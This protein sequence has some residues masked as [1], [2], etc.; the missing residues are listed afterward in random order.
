MEYGVTDYGR[1]ISDTIRM[2]AYVGALERTIKPGNVVLDIGTGTGMMAL[3]ACRLGAARVIALEPDDVIEVARQTAQANGYDDRIEFIQVR[4]TEL[5]LSK[6]AD[7]IV[8]DLR[9]VLPLYSGHIGAI[10]DARD[11]LLAEGGS[12]IPRRDTL[13]VAAVEAP[14][15]YRRNV[16]CWSRHDLGFDLTSVRQLAANTWSRE[17]V[18]QSAMLTDRLQVAVLDYATINSPDLDASCE[19]SVRRKGTA[20]GLCV[21]FDT[22]LTEGEG[23]SNAPDRPEAIYGNAFLPFEQPVALQEGDSV[24]VHLRAVLAGGDYVWGWSTG[25]ERRGA[26]AVRYRQSSVLGVPLTAAQLERSGPGFVPTLSRQGES[27]K[28]ALELMGGESTL[29]LGE[30]AARVQQDFPEEFSNESDGLAFVVRLA[31]KYS[32]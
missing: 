13:W 7:V 10:I 5:Q 8:S 6:R 32:R 18:E 21:W 16:D 15:A 24:H 9:G 22:E 2:E 28:L 1:M 26:A 4:S 29:S 23:F 31:Q 17:R 11:R 27:Q 20:H 19:L 30:I 12:M 3:V 25:F 14:D